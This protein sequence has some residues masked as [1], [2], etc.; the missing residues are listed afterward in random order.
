MSSYYYH[1]NRKVPWSPFELMT[2]GSEIECGSGYNPYYRYFLDHDLLVTVNDEKGSPHKI[3]RLSFMEDLA[4][5]K[6]QH[7]EVAKVGAESLR[8]VIAMVKE[9]LWE[10]VRVEYYN[11]LPSRQKCIWLIEN[12]GTVSHWMKRLDVHEGQRSYLKV[13][14][15]GHMHVADENW[16]YGDTYRLSKAIE[17]AHSYWSGEM[18]KGYKKEILFTGRMRVIEALE[19]QSS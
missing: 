10:S 5:R 14:C 13:T 18:T 19:L 17:D 1:I 4:R 6:I 7:P 3:G 8:H 15:D 12:E 16:L 11:S 2:V 9:L